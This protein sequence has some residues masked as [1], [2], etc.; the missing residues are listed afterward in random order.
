MPTQQTVLLVGGT[1]RTGGRVLRQLLS[2][3]IRVRAIVRSGRG[4][5][6]DIADNPC[7]MV[8]E[9]TLLSLSEEELQR[10]VRGCDAV[11]SCLGHVL[12]LKGIFGS[13][14]DLVA[15]ATSR[16]CRGVEALQPPAPVKFILMSSVSVNRPGRLDARR[17]AFERAFLWVLRG[18]LPPAKDNQRAAD[19]LLA[20]VGPNNAFVQWV[21]VRPDSLLPGEVSEY[22]SHEGLVNSLFAPGSTNMANVAH[23]M[24]ELVTNP[25][26]WAAWKGKLPVVVNASSKLA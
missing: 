25:E 21:V 23:F 9:A 12:S 5:P 1:G 6:P 19:F 22:A 26:T 17:G 20:K 3:G 10:H 13:P 4:L 14:H 8:V 18:L 24:C 15:R 11:I 7:L 2:R 16:L